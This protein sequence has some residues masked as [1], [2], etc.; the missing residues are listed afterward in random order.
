MA[1]QT[2]SDILQTARRLFAENGYVATSIGDIANEAGVAVQTIYARLGSKRGMLAALLELI[3]EESGVRDAAATILT[4][5]SPHD[6]LRGQI[7]LTRD[8]QERCG[9][10]VGALLNAA[11]VEPELG[12]TIAEGMRRHRYGARLT[13]DRIAELGGL[14]SSLSPHNAA[15]VLS[16]S[17]THDAWHELVQ[18]HGLSWHDAEAALTDALTQALLDHP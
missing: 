14:R 11:P 4:A 17:T 10:L 7:R 18:A 13:I 2:R 8:L 12:D 9:D 3:D 15:A 6:A 16:A 1:L 5:N